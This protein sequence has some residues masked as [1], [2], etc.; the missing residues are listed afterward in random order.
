MTAASSAAMASRRRHRFSVSGVLV[1]VIA[2]TPSE[3]VVST[4]PAQQLEGLA[5]WVRE[6]VRCEALGDSCCIR[7]SNVGPSLLSAGYV[8]AEPILLRG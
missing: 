8:T 5:G 6:F 3:S 1:V 4:R 7:V 2:M